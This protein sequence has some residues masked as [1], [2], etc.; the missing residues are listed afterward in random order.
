[1]WNTR[2]Q[3]VESVDSRPPALHP[4]ES[5]FLLAACPP[6]AT[7]RS[8]ICTCLFLP[9]PRCLDPNP[10]HCNRC[11]SPRAGSPPGPRIAQS[12]H[13][14]SNGVGAKPQLL[15]KKSNAEADA[16]INSR[17]L[18]HHLS[19]SRH[20]RDSTA[21]TSQTSPPGSPTPPTV[22]RSA[23]KCHCAISTGEHP[24]RCGSC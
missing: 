1:M 21:A 23:T 10:I 16:L 5:S 17:L 9:T 22:T 12:P 19:Y 24:R 8:A 7:C 13:T 18:S 6:G 4:F 3:R 15:Q 11:C 2:K 20:F 14:L